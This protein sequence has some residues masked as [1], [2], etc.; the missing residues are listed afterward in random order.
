MEQEKRLDTT[1]FN[2]IDKFYD[3]KSINRIEIY[4]P[5]FQDDY[6]I[7]ELK[8]R[9]DCENIHQIWGTQTPQEW[10]VSSRNKYPE[11]EKPQLTI[12]IDLESEIIQNINVENSDYLIVYRKSDDGKVLF[13]NEDWLQKYSSNSGDDLRFEFYIKNK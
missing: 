13:P 6:I 3:I 8:V 12:F 5:E 10:L 7:D 1:G 2:F 9:F 11:I 4:S